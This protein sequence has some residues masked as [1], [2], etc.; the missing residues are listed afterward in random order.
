VLAEGRGVVLGTEIR[1]L[2]YQTIKNEWPA[3]LGLLELSRVA[4]ELGSE[5]GFIAP[6]V[7][8]ADGWAKLKLYLDFRD[9]TNPTF[10]EKFAQYAQEH[11]RFEPVIRPRGAG[12]VTVLSTVQS[13]GTRCGIIALEPSA[14]ITT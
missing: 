14:P 2:A 1:R 7:T 3:S 8:V 5:L 6:I 10:L 13:T 9:A 4:V 12:L 11:S